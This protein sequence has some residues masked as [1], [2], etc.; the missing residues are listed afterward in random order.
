MT[1]F[2]HFTTD[3]PLDGKHTLVGCADC[4]FDGQFERTIQE[5]QGCHQEPAIHQGLLGTDCG[6]CHTEQDWKPA[7]VNGQPFEHVSQTG[8]SLAR[9]TQDYAGQPMTCLSCH[10][11]GVQ[12]FKVG[13]CGSCHAD[14]DG[15]FMDQHVQ[16]FGAACLDCHDGVDRMKDFDHSMVFPLEGRHASSACETC[17]TESEQGRVFKGTPAACYQCHTEPQIHAGFFG[18]Q[19]EYCHTT[20]GWI[21]AQLSQHKFQLDHGEQGVQACQVCHTDTYM[22]YTCYGCH[23]HQPAEIAEEHVEEGISLAELPNCTQCHPQS[24]ELDD[25]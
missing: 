4:H 12:G 7:I 24:E 13:T 10:L 2:D 11:D 14:H 22:T 20:E 1:G 6:S 25:D 5:C 9:H 15:V 19:C 23:E 17:H 16:F 8:F 3:F 21:P 18:L